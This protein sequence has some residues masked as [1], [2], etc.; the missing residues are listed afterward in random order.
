MDHLPEP[1]ADRSNPPPSI[2]SVALIVVCDDPKTN[3]DRI[4]EAVGKL[5]NCS[6]RA[7]VR[8]V[9]PGR[10]AGGQRITFRPTATIFATVAEALVDVRHARIVILDSG[11]ELSE[12]QWSTLVAG[13]DETTHA[14]FQA[15]SQGRS[16]GLLV[17]LYSIFVCLFL[18]TRKHEFTR[19]AIIFPA[20]HARQLIGRLQ[21][22]PSHDVARILSLAAWQKKNVIESVSHVSE[23]AAGRAS[24]RRVR[25]AL[26]RGIRFWYTELMF[27]KR[28]SE[29][30]RAKPKQSERYLISALLMLV[31]SVMLFGNLNYPLFEPD[32][33][34][35]AELAMALIESNDWSVLKLHQTHYWDKPPLQTWAIASSY[36]WFGQSPW[37][38]RLPIALASMFTVGC[39]FFLGRRLVGFYAATAATILLLSSIGF[40]VISRFTNMDASLTA[41]TTATFL[42]GYESVRRGFSRSKS[43]L[44]GVAAGLGLMIKGPIII[45]LCGP[46]LLLAHWFERNREAGRAAERSHRVFSDCKRLSWF[47]VPAV[48]VAGPWFAITACRYPEFVSQFFWKHNVVRFSEGFNHA[49]PSYYYL[50]GIFV[51]MFPASYLI[52]S[53]F[54]YATSQKLAHVEARSR[55]VGFLFLSAAWI[56]LFF[57]LS[58][59]KLPTYVLPAFP[60]I[61][62]LMGAMVEQWVFVTPAKRNS[63]LQQLVRRAPVEMPIWGMVFAAVGYFVLGVSL[64]QAMVIV[65]LALLGGCMVQ[66]SCLVEGPRRRRRLAWW[67]IAGVALLLSITTGHWYVPL[68]ANQRSDLAAV[69]NLTD[70]R[71]WESPIVFVGRDPHAAKQSLGQAVVYFDKNQIEEAAEFLRE[72]TASVLVVS[73]DR[74]RQLAAVTGDSIDFQKMPLGRHVY[75]SKAIE[76][77]D[78][79]TLNSR[80]ANRRSVLNAVDRRIR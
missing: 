13:P 1:A 27:P 41:M 65:V 58:S 5:R 56:F 40:V 62:L 22:P 10:Q 3:D 4:R 28:H 21:G 36:Q 73:D 12:P 69:E 11:A 57:T 24:G 50:L 29:I 80:A 46:P 8:L 2:L 15:E 35:N 14:I 51:F 76:P 23:V 55:E 52:P 6:C 7:E 19:G 49:G 18:K 53:A 78:D 67:S 25:A 20:G 32:E 71:G 9:D 59:T 64:F 77:A 48:L 44:A 54:R 47:V 70:E 72:N 74:V 37:A 39:T 43:L 31:A 61:C 38:T 34:R 33:T 68:I 26:Q 30:A 66:L 17:W 16:P 75:V 63:L 60:L 45:V 79:K 42:F